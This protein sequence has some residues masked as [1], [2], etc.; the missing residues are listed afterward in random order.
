MVG[1]SLTVDGV[2]ARPAHACAVGDVA[3]YDSVLVVRGCP[4]DFDD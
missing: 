3:E 2:S 4:L 1:G